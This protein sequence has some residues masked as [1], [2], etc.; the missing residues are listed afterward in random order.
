MGTCCFPVTEVNKAYENMAEQ[1]KNR[2][3]IMNAN[4]E[5]FISSHGEICIPI[6]TYSGLVSQT[7]PRWL[8]NNISNKNYQMFINEINNKTEPAIH[9]LLQL[10]VCKFRVH[11]SLCKIV[12]MFL[13]LSKNRQ[14]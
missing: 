3:K 7:L 1:Q 8:K 2:Y 9:N 4:S 6:N 10:F 14:K 5:P 11:H 12:C 13:R